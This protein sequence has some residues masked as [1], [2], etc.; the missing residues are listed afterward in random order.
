MFRLIFWLSK[1]GDTDV[2]TRRFFQN[3]AHQIRQADQYHQQQ[4]EILVLTHTPNFNIQYNS[5]HSSIK[6]RLTESVP[7]FSQ[8]LDLDFLVIFSAARSTRSTLTAAERTGK[9]LPPRNLPLSALLSGQPIDKCSQ[10]T[11][12]QHTQRV[13]HFLQSHI[14]HCYVGCAEGRHS[15][16]DAKQ[17]KNT[18][19]GESSSFEGLP[20]SRS[21]HHTDDTK[22]EGERGNEEV[23]GDVSIEDVLGLE[24]VVIF[25]DHEEGSG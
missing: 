2:E 4:S 20:P 25:A 19:V 18:V 14:D 22:K 1:E 23:D 15:C 13:S 12:P 8:Q 10:L 5:E 21:D 7:T 17:N 3:S 24:D 6:N 11:T 9:A 16:L